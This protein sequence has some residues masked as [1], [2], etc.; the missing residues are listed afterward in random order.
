M[1]QQKKIR[2]GVVGFGISAKVFHLPFITTLPEH[3]E[4]VS[5]LQRKGDEAKA[6]FPQAK[7][8]RT[9]EEMVNDPEID[10]IVITTPNDT[11]FPYSK[12]ALDAGKHVV[13]EKPFTNTLEE[14]KQLVDIAAKSG[15]VLS[16]YQNRRYVSDFRTIK[17]LLDNDLLGDIHE[18]EAHY[19]RYRAEERPT[20]WREA[21][22]PG[23][24]ILYDLG[25]HIIDQA[26]YFFGLPRFITVDIRLQRPHAR[27][28]D[29]FNIWL[30]YG[31]NKVI[32]HAGMLF[33]EQGP[34]YMIHGTRGS[35]IKYG[36]DPQEARLRAGELPEGEEW[37][38][39]PEDIYGL[40]HTEVDGKIIKE[41]YP[42]LKGSYADYYL[43]LYDTIV[44][45]KPVKQ[46][47]EHGYNTIRI[48]QLAIQSNAEKRTLPCTGLM[49]VS[50]KD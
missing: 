25:A 1:A 42:S 24:G 31:F 32:L 50:Y 17:A 23:S 6:Q 10:L 8:V 29:Y 37:G 36:E 28:D 22:L 21:P 12:M 19:D 18:F 38:K 15:K 5:I 48:I 45:G 9:I 2:V 35:F 43:D 16:V 47:P 39:E 13:L 46:K 30:D 49:D 34:R 26:L 11:H 41:K 40:L 3:Y 44:N 27:V 33:R 7:I 14:G 4:L 20:A